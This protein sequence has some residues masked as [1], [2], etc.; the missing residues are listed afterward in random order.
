MRQFYCI[1]SI[2][3]SWT[4]SAQVIDQ[5]GYTYKTIHIGNQEWFAENLRT[6]KYNDGTPI[7]NIT[8][9]NTWSN[10]NTGAYSFYD[11][12][13]SNNATYGKLYN[14]Y[15]VETD[16]LCPIGWHVPSVAD[17]ITLSDYLGGKWVAN[18]M[19]STSGWFNDRN[20]TNSSGFSGLPVGIRTNNGSYYGEG[21]CC[22][23][24]SSLEIGSKRPY[25]LGL[26]F[27]Y[28][29]L[30]RNRYNYHLRGGYSVRCLRD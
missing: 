4:F 21:K 30:E 9:K 20:G 14:W 2:C 15:A 28:I 12:N 10:L 17:W 6:S 8:D 5:E 3:I 19:K 22:Y 23:W 27:N 29:G 13:E 11:N 18:K 7:P 24:W 16:K 1:I 26:T 25:I